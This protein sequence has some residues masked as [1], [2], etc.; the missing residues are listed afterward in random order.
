MRGI[1]GQPVPPVAPLHARPAPG[2]VIAR[3]AV[4]RWVKAWNSTDSYV[5]LSLSRRAVGQLASEE[6]KARWQADVL[7]PQVKVLQARL[8]VIAHFAWAP[9]S[10]LPRRRAWCARLLQA[11]V[12][13]LLAREQLR[14]A[15][16][17][18]VL[19]QAACRGALV[20]PPLRPRHTTHG[21]NPTALTLP[22]LA[23]LSD[24]NRGPRSAQSTPRQREGVAVSLVHVSCKLRFCDRTQAIGR[25]TLRI[26][27]RTAIL[28]RLAPSSRGG[29]ELSTQSSDQS[30]V[31]CV[32]DS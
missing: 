18:T 8:G 24:E 22:L 3:D 20:R 2:A 28:I 9:G 16:T 25:N 31:R 14:R 32:A 17:G 19:L 15:W 7:A 4:T 10:A 23:S 27:I 11:R 5:R 21:S 29:L 30:E 13:G 1:D 26:Y 6:A 12:R